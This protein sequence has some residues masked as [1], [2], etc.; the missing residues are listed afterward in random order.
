M[1]CHHIFFA[2]LTLVITIRRKAKYRPRFRAA[3]LL[4]ISSFY[5]RKIIKK[6][7]IVV[8]IALLPQRIQVQT[9]SGAAPRRFE[10]PTCSHYLGYE[11]KKCTV[12]HEL[13][14]TV[15]A[16][17]KARNIFDRSNTEIMGSYPTQGMD[18][19]VR[20]FCV[21]VR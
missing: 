18:V 17:Y 20:L 5:K 13:P 7:Y 6:V 3:A 1:R 4:F 11:L 12:S 16:R 8:I 2:C 14:I 9:L 15:A 10:R 19:C 21:C